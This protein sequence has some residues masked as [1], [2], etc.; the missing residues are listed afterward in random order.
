MNRMVIAALLGVIVGVTIAY[1]QAVQYRA[2]QG[3]QPGTVIIAASVPDA[4][5][6]CLEPPGGGLLNCTKTVG[7]LR[8]WATA[9]SAK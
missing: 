2:E 4:N 6:V 9:R 1:A 7:E 8:R 3:Y 5:R